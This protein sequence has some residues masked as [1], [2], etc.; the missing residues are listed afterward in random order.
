MA[1]LLY[2]S[3]DADV[4]TDDYW[5]M[6]TLKELF[7]G[8]LWD[9][10]GM[11]EL[12]RKKSFEDVGKGAVIVFPAR[13]QV[14]YIDQLN[15]DLKRL[16]WVVLMLVGDEA[17]EFPAD[18]IQHP[19]MKL[20]IMSAN[21]D[22]H[23]EGARKIGSGVPPQG[24]EWLPQFKEDAYNKPVDYFF[25]GQITHDRRHG[26]AT[27]LNT[28]E[29]FK[30]GNKLEGVKFFSEGFTRG[31]PAEHYFHGLAAAKVVPCP[32]GAINPDSFRLY[33]ALE[34]GCIPVVDA[35]APEVKHPDYWTWFFDEEPPFPVYTDFDQ[36]RGYI[37][38]SAAKTPA[39]AN[40][41]FAWW[42]GKK[43][44]MAYWLADDIAELTS[45]SRN[46]VDMR[47]MITVIV[48]SSPVPAH[49]STEMIEQTIRDIRV[50]LPSVEI[51]IT[52]DGIR[53]EQEHYREA[54]EEYTKRLLW[55]AN[56]EWH[57]VLPIV[58]EEHQHQARMARKV[59]ELV[60]TPT[61]L[62]AEHD[63]PLTP[64]RPIDFV[65][66][67]R[68]IMDGTANVIRFSHESLILPEHKHL[69]L[70]DAEA[71]HDIK[72]TKTQQ[73]SQ[74]PHLASTAFYR[75]MIQTYFHPE[76]RTMIED[77]IHQIVE[78]DMRNGAQ[79]WFN[80][81][82]W[83]YTMPDADGSILRSYNLDGRQADPKYDM[84]IVP[85]EGK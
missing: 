10:V 21:P 57:N 9:A 75:H 61:I 14:Q 79:A 77:V 40:K 42:Q 41:I 53:P 66:A 74:R 51:F 78:M 46:T 84:D 18:K 70:S 34:A 22:K 48:P 27:E 1:D 64:D 30:D 19:N 63:T 24:Y 32:S 54:Y 13:R 35:I 62:Y 82:I 76:S 69:I 26:L 12:E 73:W 17:Q 59:L 67:V 80:W 29:E 49:P 23:V 2:L 85:V 3:Y 5:D 81:R 11:P 43:R 56:H 4:P 52:V 39:L 60:K 68:T 71:H 38:D 31:L 45:F 55:L 72:I 28:L 83:L 47:D 33:E 7:A 37:I 58:F 15:D 36:I 20:W 8:R 65:N 16:E 50:H 25:A 44:Q 6:G